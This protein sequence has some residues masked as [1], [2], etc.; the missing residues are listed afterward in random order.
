[1]SKWLFDLKKA[2]EIY[3]SK[4]AL[5]E[6]I[7]M[8]PNAMTKWWIKEPPRSKRQLIALLIRSKQNRETAERIK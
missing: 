6:A 2:V 8:A 7:G 1:M 4:A 5:A 3:G